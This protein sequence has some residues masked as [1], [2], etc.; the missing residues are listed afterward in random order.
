MTITIDKKEYTSLKK[1]ALEYRKIA[2][3]VF[4]KAISNPTEG[5]VRD[6]KNTDLYSL[7]FLRDLEFGLSKSSLNK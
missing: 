6:F 3:S 1:D 5:I 2:G 4:K 7:E